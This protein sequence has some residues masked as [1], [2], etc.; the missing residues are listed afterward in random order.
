MPSAVFPRPSNVQLITTSG[1]TVP[2]GRRSITWTGAIQ[3][4]SSMNVGRT[5][6]ET[7]HPQFAGRADAENFISWLRW[8]WSTQTVFTVKHLMTP[9]S[10]LPPNGTGTGGVTVSG[11]GQTGSSIVTTGWPSSTTNVARAGDLIKI[12]GVGYTLEVT[13]DANSSGAVATLKVNPPVWTA[14]STG[15]AVTTT[16]V[17]INAVTM[18]LTIPEISNSFYYDQISVEFREAPE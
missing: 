10:G 7:Y 18:S 16:N 15:A 2:S 13:D 14:P 6:S 8:A 3:T 9:G 12:A 5:W 17:N 1:I 11:G 4:R